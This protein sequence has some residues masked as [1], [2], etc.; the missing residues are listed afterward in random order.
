[1]AAPQGF[2][3]NGLRSINHLGEAGGTE[4][5]LLQPIAAVTG[6]QLDCGLFRLA[7]TSNTVRPEASTSGLI[8]VL[9][10]V[11]KIEQ[12]ANPPERRL[13]SHRLGATVFEEILTCYLC[14]QPVDISAACTDGRGK[15][16]HSDCY[17]GLL[18]ES[19]NIA[20]APMQPAT[21]PQISN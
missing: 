12:A 20:L 16:V 1:M 13:V 18:A 15:A 3:C 8:Y 21:E 5:N 10:N 6:L 11:V 17:A 14:H 4:N 2:E 7:L 19:M 9:L